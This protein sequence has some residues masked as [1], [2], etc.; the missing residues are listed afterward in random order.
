MSYDNT[1]TGILAKNE[2]KEKDTDPG[3]TGSVN[4][5]GQEFWLSAWVNEGKPGGKLAGQKYFSIKVR[6]KDEKPRQQPAKR[7]SYGD[8]FDDIPI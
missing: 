1:N 8:D 3:Y 7:P 6:A 2:R 5:N 4:I